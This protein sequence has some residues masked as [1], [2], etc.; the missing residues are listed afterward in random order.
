[1]NDIPF[2]AYA[3]QY[4]HWFL[5]NKH[6]LDS[7]VKL[8][9]HALGQSIGRCISVG[10]GSG[11]FE[12]ALARDFN[13]QIT[14]GVEPSDGMRAI[15]EKRGLRVQA[16]S[17]DSMVLAEA[18]YDTIVFN[19]ISSYLPDPAAAF[20]KAYL[21]LKEGGRLLVLDVPKESAYGLLYNFG[22]ETGGWSHPALEG[23]TPAQIYPLEF[24]KSARWST[25]PEKMAQLETIGFHSLTTA[26]T[27]VRHPAYSNDEVEEPVAGF[28]RGSYVCITAV[29]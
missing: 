25:T 29:R 13:I 18:A 21:A 8:L 15:A 26:Q 22:S 5:A 1:M 14:E 17:A 6:V 28:D 20:R 27:L 11:L 24:V 2:D 10:C 12:V 9:A 7:E 3:E 23:V 19:G 16:A 4:D